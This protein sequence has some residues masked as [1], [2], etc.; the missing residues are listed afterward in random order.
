MRFIF[1]ESLGE[2]FYN[3]LTF[4]YCIVPY[5]GLLLKQLKDFPYA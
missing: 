1:A 2:N 4:P 3:L 5:K